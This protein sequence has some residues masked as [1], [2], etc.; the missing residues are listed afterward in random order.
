[1]GSD[2]VVDLVQKFLIIYIVLFCVHMIYFY[3][4]N[5]NKK[6]KNVPT[7]EMM[8]LIRIYQVDVKRLGINEVEKHI[9][10]INS[11][12]MTI[13]FI[14]YFSMSS[15]LLKMIIMFL[16]TLISVYISYTTLGKHYRKLLYRW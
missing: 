14:I 7:F 6:Y 9:A 2:V 8:F 16:F 11:F 10:F 13:D 1:M 15:M 12:I 3:F 4:R 5:K